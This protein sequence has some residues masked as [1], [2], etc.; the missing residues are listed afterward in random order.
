MKSWTIRQRILTSFGI[1]LGL[2]VVMGILALRNLENIDAR[3]TNAASASVPGLYASTA[4]QSELIINYSLTAEYLGQTDVL[5]VQKIEEALQA[6]E[7]RWEEAVDRYDA[8]PSDA[9]TDAM[10][11]DLEGLLA[12][13]GI[14]VRLDT[15][16]AHLWPDPIDRELALALAA[17]TAKADGRIDPAER[18][19]ILELA[20]RLG[21]PGA[22]VADWLEASEEDP[23]LLNA[24]PLS[25]QG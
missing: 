22:R 20:A 3:A 25:S 4:V 13:D 5:R 2:M 18:S 10:L 21:V 17:A 19:A 12:R 1:V 11:L 8:L 6:N 23:D 14:D 16:A 9:A 15:V 7:Q 24:R